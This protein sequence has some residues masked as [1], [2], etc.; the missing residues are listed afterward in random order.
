MHPGASCTSF[1]A[2]PSRSMTNTQP[3]GATPIQEA[4]CADV[5]EKRYVNS[6]NSALVAHFPTN[7]RSALD[8]GCG[9]GAHARILASRGC[10]VDGITLS[11][12][13]HTDARPFC[14]QCWIHDL[15]HGLPS[16]IG[17]D[18]DLVVASHVLE[19]LRWPDRLLREIG[20]VLAPNHGRLLCALPN[21]LFYKNRLRMLAGRFE[22][23]E[24]GIMDAS[25]FRWFT[26]ESAAQ[27]IQ[28][29]GFRIVRHF[30]DGNAPLPVIRNLLPRPVS[31]T[32]DQAA[33]NALPG[34]FASQIIMIAEPMLPSTIRS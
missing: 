23:E 10:E 17:S 20:S 4:I 22:Y 18:Y 26:F 30:G 33:T 28:Q 25:H 34:V 12:I 31:M 27:L 13:E 14:R 1:L 16:G 7:A 29:A 5:R 32:I 8:V 3:R 21:V 24:S 6:G 15:E 11:K 9:S 19:H 2:T